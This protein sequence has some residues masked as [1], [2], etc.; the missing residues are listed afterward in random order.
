MR[1]CAINENIMGMIIKIA[2]R[3]IWRNIM[4]SLVV[5]GAIIIGIWS[6]IFLV[7]MV[8]G[9][10]ESYINNAIKNEVSHIKIH[11][12]DFIND[13]ES[14]YFISDITAIKNEVDSITGVKAVSYKTITNA[15]ISSSHAGRGI[16]AIGVVPKYETNV[17][18]VSQKMIAGKYLTDTKKNQILISKRTAKKLKVKLRSKVVLT[19]QNLDNEIT[20][21]AFRVVGMFETGN[22]IYDE[23]IVFVCQKDLNTLLDINGN[24]HEVAILID[25]LSELDSIQAKISKMYPDLLVRNYKEVQ[26]EL[27]LFQSQIKMAGIIYMVIFMLALVFGIINTMMMAVLERVRELGMLMSVGMNKM[28]IFMMIVVET[29]LLAM[30]AAPV[31]LILGYMTT[32][33]FNKNGINLFFYS[34]EGMKQFGF[35]NFIYPNVPTDTYWQLVVAVS[36]TA[37]L[38]SL[39]PAWKAIRLRPVEAIRG[40]FETRDGLMVWLFKFLRNKIRSIWT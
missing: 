7:G 15:M 29:I 4:R 5:I 14:K 16:M 31:G 22:N 39:Y 2:W 37:L 6:I 18:G 34:E 35:D 8:N 9:M 10:I 1:Q 27:A 32:S 20:M 17:S 24:G 11:H 13:K 38:G 12:P 30:V 25:D 40:S 28:K 23:S 3:N 36:L 19:F 21:G 26:P 33:Y